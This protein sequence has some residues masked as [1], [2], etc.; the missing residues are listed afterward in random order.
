MDGSLQFHSTTLSRVRGI[1]IAQRTPP[2]SKLS[3]VAPR[4]SYGTVR[5]IRSRPK[6]RWA[7]GALL[8]ACAR[9]G[10]AAHERAHEAEH[11]ARAMLKLGDE[12]PVL[13]LRPAHA[14]GVRRGAE[15]LGDRVGVVRFRVMRRAEPV[16]ERKPR[17]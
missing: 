6:P 12:Q 15:P 8:D 4:S 5:S 9:F 13:A 16:G 2:A 17:G 7:G 1:S 3:R 11:V 10:G 14:F